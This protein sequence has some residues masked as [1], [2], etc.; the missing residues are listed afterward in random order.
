M[1]KLMKNI[2]YKNLF[3]KSEI[4]NSINERNGWYERKEYSVLL[5]KEIHR[6]YRSNS[7]LSQVVIKFQ[8]KTDSFKKTA[9]PYI[10]V[11]K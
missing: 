7:P 2:N 10:T 4:Q 1:K 8:E 9:E 5:K 6:S 11:F 3:T